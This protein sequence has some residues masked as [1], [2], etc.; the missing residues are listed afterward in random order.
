MTSWTRGGNVTIT[1][2]Q[3]LLR[4]IRLRGALSSAYR[5]HAG[6]PTAR[7]ADHTGVVIMHV[8]LI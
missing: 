2:I 7:V 4:C 3:L 6:P 8:D 1:R 5:T